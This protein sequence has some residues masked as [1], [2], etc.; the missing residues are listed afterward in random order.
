MG[1]FNITEGDDD[2]DVFGDALRHVQA[3]GDVA[4]HGIL[5]RRNNLS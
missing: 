5:R 3:R 4:N 2:V 1:K